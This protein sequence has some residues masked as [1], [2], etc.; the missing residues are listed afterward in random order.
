M[1]FIKKWA[2]AFSQLKRAISNYYNPDHGF[3]TSYGTLEVRRY[4]TNDFATQLWYS[5]S[6]D[7]IYYRRCNSDGTYK[8]WV[9]MQMS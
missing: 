7:E 5:S 2:T 6:S 9:K 3:P 1:H 4:R 8:A